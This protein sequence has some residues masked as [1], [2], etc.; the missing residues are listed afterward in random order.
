MELNTVKIRPRGRE[1]YRSVKLT[2]DDVMIR[3]VSK[4]ENKYLRHMYSRL[5]D[6]WVLCT[7]N[8]ITLETC[9]CC[10]SIYMQDYSGKQQEGI[11][12]PITNLIITPTEME[13][14]SHWYEE[15]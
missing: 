9:G 12:Y 14:V 2:K 15:E 5:L 13:F 7:N 11:Y 3:F 4:S 10:D 6:L 8:H 1:Q